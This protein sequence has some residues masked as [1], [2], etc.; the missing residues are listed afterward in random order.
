MEFMA[1]ISKKNM[2]IHYRQ[3]NKDNTQN[4]KKDRKVENIK[5][6]EETFQMIKQIC[7]NNVQAQEPTKSNYY[8]HKNK[9]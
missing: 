8:G 1:T 3:L 4:K 9:N 7:T 5:Q 6:K 2:L